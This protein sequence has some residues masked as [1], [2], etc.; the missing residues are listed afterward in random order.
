VNPARSFA[1]ALFGE[2]WGWE[3]L[4]VFIVFPLVGGVIG[5]GIWRLVTTPEEE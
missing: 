2:S 3:Q 5:A 4:W 1:T